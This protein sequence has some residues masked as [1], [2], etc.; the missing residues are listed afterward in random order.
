MTKV[1]M[2]EARD[3]PGIMQLMAKQHAESSM[4]FLA[5]EGNSMISFFN[6]AFISEDKLCLV[7]E[8]EEV[9]VGIFA[10]VIN[11][12]WFFKGKIAQ[13]L[14]V[15]VVPEKRGSNIAYRLL[16]QFLCWAKAQEATEAIAGTVM[17]SETETAKRIYEG[18]GFRTVGYLFKKRIA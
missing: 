8:D 9:I 18:L 11:P 15:F 6:H 5:V 16:K 17:E 4:A 13:E 3:L 12:Y 14:T 1:R 7:A 2:G 10:A